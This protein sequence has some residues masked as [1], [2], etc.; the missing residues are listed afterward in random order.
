MAN[1]YRV[2]CRSIVSDGTNIFL[3]V[4]IYNGSQTLPLIRP[5]FEVGTSRS[6]ILAYLQQIAD[7]QPV[8]SGSLLDLVN[9]VVVGA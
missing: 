1:A 7:N 4:E 8:L 2:T 3:E 5:V 6:T 9:N